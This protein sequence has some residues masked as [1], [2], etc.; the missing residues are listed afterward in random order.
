M[1]R[2][3]RRQLVTDIGNLENTFEE[4]FQGGSGAYPDYDKMDMKKLFA[5]EKALLGAKRL[6]APFNWELNH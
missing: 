5:F 3:S 2:R 4:A 6:L 1:A